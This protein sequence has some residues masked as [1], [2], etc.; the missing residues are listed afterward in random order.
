MQGDNLGDSTDSRYYGPVPLALIQGVVFAR[1]YASPGWIRR[2]MPP[3]GQEKEAAAEAWSSAKVVAPA[4][5]RQAEGSVETAEATTSGG[6]VG[7]SGAA[8]GDGAEGSGGAARGA[9]RP[10]ESLSEMQIR[11][12]DEARAPATGRATTERAAAREA[13][14]AGPSPPGVVAHDSQ[15]QI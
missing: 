13:A 15:H 7:G 4:P 12:R 5:A 10:G 6:G 1:V 3:P 9:R 2:Q 14:E 8:G 11:L